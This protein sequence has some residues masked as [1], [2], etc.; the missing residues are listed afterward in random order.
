[1]FDTSAKILA[2]R[3]KGKQ[4]ISIEDEYDVQDIL[5][6]ILKSRFPD[7]T[8]IVR[9]LSGTRTKVNHVF[10]VIVEIYPR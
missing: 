9:G 5:H 3:R 4:T 2:S 1:M 10:E 7:I 6:C 8:S